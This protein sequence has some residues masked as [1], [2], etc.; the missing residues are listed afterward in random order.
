MSKNMFEQ[1][2][3]GEIK[4]RI[5]GLTPNST[6]AWGKMG[7]AQ[8]LA[9]CANALEYATGDARP[10]RMLIGRVLGP[11]VKGAV[12]G[13]KPMGRNAPTA[14]DLRIVDERDL[15]R[16]KQRLSA[17]VDRFAAAG[18]QGCTTHP[19]TFFGPLKPDEWARLSYKH[20][21]HH[22]RQFSA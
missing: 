4:Q 22:L 9:H 13:E 19:H 10:P 3:V 7:V 12:L 6:R 1:N 21:D 8:M 2:T 11:L 15:E 16:E 20:I 17:L 14:P 18:P 5:A